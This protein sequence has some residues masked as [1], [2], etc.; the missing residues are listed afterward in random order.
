MGHPE[1]FTED[2]KTMAGDYRR[3]PGEDPAQLGRSLRLSLSRPRNFAMGSQQIRATLG[4]ELAPIP[5]ALRYL[6]SDDRV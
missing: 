5:P 4:G 3:V 6:D 2:V 1:G